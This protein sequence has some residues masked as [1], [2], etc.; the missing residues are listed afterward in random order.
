MRTLAPHRHYTHTRGGRGRASPGGAER[1]RPEPSV[2]GRERTLT[3]DG[4]RGRGRRDT[5]IRSL[6]YRYTSKFSYIVKLTEYIKS[7]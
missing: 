2:A 3:S 7:K 6:L 5:F 4:G 1:R